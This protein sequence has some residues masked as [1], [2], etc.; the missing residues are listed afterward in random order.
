MYEENQCLCK[1]FR[2]ASQSTHEETREVEICSYYQRL[3]CFLSYKI[4]M[5]SYVCTYPR[6]KCTMCLIH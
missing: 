5:Y 4:F 3:E 1:N 6:N 2:N